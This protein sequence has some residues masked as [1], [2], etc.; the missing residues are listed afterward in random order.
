M[1]YA[2]LVGAAAILLAGPAMAGKITL[3][4]DD[5]CEDSFRVLVDSE[6][7][8]EMLDFRNE[9]ESVRVENGTWTLHRDVNFFSQSGPSLTVGPG[10]CVNLGEGHASSFPGDALDS[11]QLLQRGNPPPG[12]IILYANE[13]LE[14]PY[15]YVITNTTELDD[16]DFNDRTESVRVVIGNWRLYR[17][18][19]FRAGGGPPVPVGPGNYPDIELLGFPD[20]EA[21]SV[22]RI[23]D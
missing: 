13:N 11:V 9:T 5:D 2:V 3:Y 8:L 14:P 15:R 7:D 19:Y 22:Q 17:D 23:R 6:A 21:S 12:L 20:D 1:R 18:E 10:G 16:Q 4:D